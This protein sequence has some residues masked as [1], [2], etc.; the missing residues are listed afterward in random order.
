MRLSGATA[1]NEVLSSVGTVVWK[2]SLP[3][4]AGPRSCSPLG[5]SST[6]PLAILSVPWASISSLMKRLTWRALRLASEV[7]FLPLSSSS[8]TCIGRKTSCSSNRNSAVGS[9]ISTFVSST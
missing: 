3:M 1:P 7:P 9:C 6:R 4:L 2:R 5:R 8:M